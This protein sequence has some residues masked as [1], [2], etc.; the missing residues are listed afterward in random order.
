VIT[1]AGTISATI[2]IAKV[3]QLNPKISKYLGKPQK[4]MKNLAVIAGNTPI[5]IIPEAQ[6]I[7][8]Q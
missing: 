6:A 2:I 4:D 8:P 7:I 1:K 5:L 3:E